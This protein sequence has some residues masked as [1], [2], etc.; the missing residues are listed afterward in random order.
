[1]NTF[2]SEVIAEVTDVEHKPSAF[3]QSGLEHENDSAP[4]IPQ[5]LRAGRSASEKHMPDP[6]KTGNL[7]EIDL[8]AEG[9]QSRLAPGAVIEGS[10]RVDHGISVAGKVTGTVHCSSGVVVIEPGGSVGVGIQAV[11]KVIVAGTVGQPE[12]AEENDAENPAI[13]TPST[14]VVLGSGS[15]FGRHEYGRIATYDDATI[16]GMGKKISR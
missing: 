14:L 12:K 11:D 6:V 4:I 8:D 9:V 13:R 7:V 16:E 3:A 5:S 15:V 10:I 1:M 2:N